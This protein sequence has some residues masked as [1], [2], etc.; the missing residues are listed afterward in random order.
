[1]PCTI[2]VFWENERL[3]MFFSIINVLFYVCKKNR[4]GAIWE[5]EG[6]QQE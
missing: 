2:L 5:E 6:D 4:R 3:K 1:M